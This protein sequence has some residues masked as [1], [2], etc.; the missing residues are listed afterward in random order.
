[1]TAV[2]R[3]RIGA[4]S[5][6]RIREIANA[7][8]G[9]DD[10]LPFWFGESDQPTPEFIRQAGADALLAGRTF[11]TQ[12]YGIPPLRQALSD[13]LTRL[14]GRPVSP[15][16]VTVTSAGISALMIAMQSILDPGDRV[17]AVTPVWPNLCEIP[18]ILNA[19]VEE[20]ALTP[21]DGRWSLDLDRLIEA[22]KPGVRLLLINSPGN[23]TGWMLDEAS[24]DV[25]LDHCR[26]L[27]I[28][29][30][31]DDVYERLPLEGD[32]I[33]APTFARI[34]TDDDRVISVN[35][36]S[37]AWRMTGWRLGWLVLPEPLAADLGKLMEFNTPCAPDFVQAGAI[38]ALEQGDPE[39][40]AQ[41][42]EL[43]AN[44]DLLC[45]ALSG[46]PGVECVTPDGGMYV[47]F[48]MNGSQ[49][50]M[51]FCRRL[52][53]E[54]GLGL[55][56]GAAFGTGGEGW[57]RWCF[58]SRPSTIEKGIGRLEAWIAR[59]QTPLA[60]SARA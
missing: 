8:M 37:K 27:G 20:V 49:D 7:A 39:T 18:R 2:A 22:L 25:I 15:S 3:S 19:E 54:A 13:Y 23:P 11:Y 41:L 30:I 56:P 48:R 59:H 35:S 28:W 33:A 14:H 32:S 43:R 60:R 31:G 47:F 57:L 24:R 40:E 45:G 21:R 34:A 58:A 29:I 53:D 44:R 16:R 12:S 38:V 55:A 5:G 17:V 1:M 26:R 6:S 42:A 52:I 9:R 4:L 51:E 10:V 46:L 36:F 50:S